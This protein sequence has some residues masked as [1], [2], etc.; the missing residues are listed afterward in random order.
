VWLALGQ[1]RALAAQ[2]MGAEGGAA[3]AG[4][5]SAQDMLNHQQQ[6]LRQQQQALSPHHTQMEARASSRDNKLKASGVHE[7][8]YRLGP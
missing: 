8:C 5:A 6:L 7:F 1:G 3:A 4:S 2:W